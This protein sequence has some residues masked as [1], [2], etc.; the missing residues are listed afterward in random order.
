MSTAA[1][2]RA[3]LPLTLDAT[4]RLRANLIRSAIA[5]FAPD[6][7]LVDKKPFGV[8]DELS[9]ALA[10]MAPPARPAEAGAAAARHPRHAETTA[11]IWRKNGYFEAISAYYDQVLVVGCPS[12]FDLR[13]S[14]PS[15]PSPRPRCLLRLHRPR[16][17]PPDT[18]PVRSSSAWPGPSRWC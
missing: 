9:G 18:R 1:T 3:A 13:A 2:A 4:V 5:D 6:L 10:E 11:R 16:A 15:R 14:T 12:V 8:E 17:R 7:I